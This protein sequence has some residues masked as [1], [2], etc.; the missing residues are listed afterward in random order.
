MTSETP[1]S[2]FLRIPAAPSN[3][4][5]TR[6]VHDHSESKTNHRA[7]QINFDILLVRTEQN[8]RIGMDRVESTGLAQIKPKWTWIQNER[9]SFVWG[10]D[11]I[12]DRKNGDLL[13][14]NPLSLE[15]DKEFNNSKANGVRT[16]IQ[17]VE[18]GT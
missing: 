4:W 6:F 15:R 9:G 1:S 2:G 3:T 16:L 10:S 13:R 8:V 5:T 17:S 12:W 14:V 7:I 11:K 18:H